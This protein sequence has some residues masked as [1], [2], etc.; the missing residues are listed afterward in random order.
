MHPSSN[1]L[2]K[3]EIKRNSWVFVPTKDTIVYGKE[4]KQIIESNW[5]IPKYYFH[6]RSGGHVKALKKT[7]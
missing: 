6:L 3:F 2:S 4:I 7:Y 5:S 1:W